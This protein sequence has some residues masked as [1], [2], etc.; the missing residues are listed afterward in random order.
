MKKKKMKDDENY[1]DEDNEE[2][3][4]VEVE[5]LK[6]CMIELE[7]INQKIEVYDEYLKDKT[8]EFNGYNKIS[9]N[10]KSIPS[11]LKRVFNLIFFF[12]N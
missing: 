12:S 5:E 9:P 2:I 1:S 10:D 6:Q 11:E 3:E 4:P 7:K 8:L